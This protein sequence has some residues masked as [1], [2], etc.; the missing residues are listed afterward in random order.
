VDSVFEL[1][2]GEKNEKLSNKRNGYQV[3]EN[4]KITEQGKRVIHDQTQQRRWVLKKWCEHN[5][6]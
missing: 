2:H 5:R 1:V 4:E 3:E 6:M